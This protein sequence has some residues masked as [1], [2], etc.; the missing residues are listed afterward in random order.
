VFASTFLVLARDAHVQLVISFP[1][2]GSIRA[3]GLVQF[4]RTAGPEQLP[5]LG[6][7][8]TDLAAEDREVITH[9]AERVRPPMLYDE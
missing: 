6:V 3:A 1:D 4:V 7:A 5:G 8:F 9:F 2:R